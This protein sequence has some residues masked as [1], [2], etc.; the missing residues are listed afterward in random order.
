MNKDTDPFSSEELE[1]ICRVLAAT[2]GGL[3]GSEIN[4]ILQ[5]LNIEDINPNNTK[6]QRLFN[7]LAKKQNETQKGNCILAF[8]NKAL[9]PARY[10]DQHPYYDEK[11]RKINVILSFHGLQYREDGKFHKIKKA[12]TL[13]DAEGKASRLRDNLLYRNLH[14]ELLHY[15]RAELISDNYFH[16]VLEACKGVAEKIRNIT[17]LSIDGADLIN[18][19]FG[20]QSPK[21]KINGFSTETEKSEQRGFL[22]L[23]I[24]LFGTFRNPTAHAPKVIWQMS[25]DDA[26]DLLTLVSYT[27]RRIDNRTL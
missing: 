15:C 1:H 11:L 24:G 6:W 26:L 19:A 8:I 9:A 4:Y 5:Q 7:A 23:M 25:E 22:N 10:I 13:T 17:N 20:G 21:I 16:A 3:T 12:E 2:E 27:L 18:Q 14:P